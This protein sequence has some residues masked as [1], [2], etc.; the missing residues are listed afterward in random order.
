MTEVRDIPTGLIFGNPNQPRRIFDQAELEDL[1][2]SIRERGQLQPCVVVTRASKFMITMGERRWRA[3]CLN[4]AP[5]VPCIVREMSDAEVLIDAIVENRQRADVSPLEEAGA[6]QAALDLGFTEQEL[7]EKLGLQQAWRIRDRTCLLRLKAEYQTLLAKSQITPTQAWEMAQLSPGG[8]DR[9]FG[10]I[11]RGECPTAAL[12]RST[13]LVLRDADAQTDIFGAV[14]TLA[15]PT[16]NERQ[17]APG[18][19]AGSTRSPRCSGRRSSRTRSWRAARS[20]PRGPGR[21]P[22]SWERCRLTL[23]AS[24]RA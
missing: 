20:T 14:E 22:T 21:W 8:Q 18:S 6:F 19:S 23:S 17:L 3:Q 2:A 9:L 4:R 5:T 10:A 7:A 24:R 16:A 13:A 12:L 1:A 11:R 15:E